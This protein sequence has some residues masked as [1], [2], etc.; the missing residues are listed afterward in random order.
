MVEMV[1]M[2]EIKCQVVEVEVL[3]VL[4]GVYWVRN[5]RVTLRSLHS[6]L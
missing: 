4:G 1:E 2:V 5:K 6:S 3:G